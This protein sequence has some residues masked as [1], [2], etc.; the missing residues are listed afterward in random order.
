MASMS[1]G[2]TLIELMIVVAIIGIFAAVAIPLYQDY[3]IK[4][5]LSRA[6]GE[7]SSY[8]S[9]M[10][11]RVSS[12]A[13]VDNAAIGYT[14]SNLTNGES[15]VNV[16]ILNADGSGYIEV[17]MG[18]VAHQKLSGVVIRLERAAAGTWGCLIDSAAV[19]VTWKPEYLPTGCSS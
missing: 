12:S 3:V 8:K 9:T 18:G 13:S 11:E 10:E 19:A 7:L 6:V 16:A 5:Q 2:F 17:T 1:R 4:S 15:G 14:P